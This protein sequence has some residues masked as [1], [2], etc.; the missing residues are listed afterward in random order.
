MPLEHARNLVEAFAK[1]RADIS[2]DR[3]LT[4]EG[5]AHAHAKVRSTTLAAL[6]AWHEARLKGLDADLLQQRAA[7]MTQTER[8]DHA[9][10]TLMA[11]SW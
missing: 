8:P 10:V 3:K 9:R 2:A 5:K 1:L 11:P 7:L 6:T 4:P